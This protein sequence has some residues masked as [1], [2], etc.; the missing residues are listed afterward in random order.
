MYTHG[1]PGAVLF[2]LY[3]TPDHEIARMRDIERSGITGAMAFEVMSRVY[4]RWLTVRGTEDEEYLRD[5]TSRVREAG[6]A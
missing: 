5:L 3:D 2:P 4:R 6:S 1:A